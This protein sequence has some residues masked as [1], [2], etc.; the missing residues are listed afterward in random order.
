MLALRVGSLLWQACP[1]GEPP[2]AGPSC[3]DPIHQ[4]G[5]VW[6]I[7]AVVAVAVIT[8]AVTFALAPRVK[9]QQRRFAALVVVVYVMAGL[10]SVTIINAFSGISLR[11]MGSQ[12]VTHVLQILL[13]PGFVASYLGG[14][15]GG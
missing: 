13:W 7:L 14:N 9:N 6:P 1:P 15:N 10:V 8:V 11:D 3:P 2:S 5:G 4:A 12:P